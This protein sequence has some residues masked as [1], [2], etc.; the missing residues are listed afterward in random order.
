MLRSLPL[1]IAVLLCLPLAGQAETLREKLQERRE[2]RSEQRLLDALPDGSR[3]LRDQAYGPH[4]RQRFDVYLPSAAQDAPIL[5]MVHGGGW[6]TGD[7]ARD[8]VVENKA[9]HWLKKGYILVSANYRLLPDA[10]PLTQAGDVAQAVAAVQRQ[11]QRWG[12]DPA[13]LV[14]MG[15]SAGAHLV[16]L[17]NSEPNLASAV[18]HP[19]LGTVALDSAAFDVSAIMQQRHLPLY[20]RA[21]GQDSRYWTRASPLHVLRSGVPPLLAVCS[22]HRRD[23]CPQADAYAARAR[24]LAVTVHVLR[25]QRSHGEINADLGTDASYTTRVDDFFTSLGLP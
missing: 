16:T 8:A 19:W 5:F 21:F 14:L 9:R 18:S 17:L 11:A 22:T 7:K 12:G 1:L 25:E 13:R 24:Q 15:H 23:A 10:D 4:P 20:D 6:Y 3:V 2:A